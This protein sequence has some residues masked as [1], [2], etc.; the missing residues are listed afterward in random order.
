MSPGAAF[1]V[2]VLIVTFGGRRSGRDAKCETCDA[3]VGVAPGA[4]VLLAAKPAANRAMVNVNVPCSPPRM[5]SA[6]ATVT[7]SPSVNAV[8]GSKLAPR[9]SEWATTRPVC[10]PLWLPVTVTVPRRGAVTPRKL[11]VVFGDAVGVPGDGNT[12]TTPEARTAAGRG[13]GSPRV[14]P[15]A[16]QPAAGSATTT[17]TAATCR[18][19][20]G[21]GGRIR[22]RSY[23]FSWEIADSGTDH[24]RRESQST[25]G[26]KSG[27]ERPIFSEGQN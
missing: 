10:A 24:P 27:A 9:P 11:I 14:A 19:A 15:A 7:R 16:V 26:L 6:V 18:A 23:P 2:F 3:G 21:R 13:V 4:G 17:A 20:T 25:S 12:L 1:C 22:A 5:A 8:A